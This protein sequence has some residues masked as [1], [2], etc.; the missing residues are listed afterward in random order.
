M[1]R[2][3]FDVIVPLFD[4]SLCLLTLRLF[5]L[6]RFPFLLLLLVRGD[7]DLL[8]YSVSLPVPTPTHAHVKP[9]ITQVYS[10]RQ[11]PPVSNPTLAASSLDQVHSDD[12]L[13]AFCKGMY[14]CTHRISLFVSYNHFVFLLFLYCIHGFYHS[15]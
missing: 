4:D 5:Q 11:N 2:K 7:D 15:S 12:L 9:F 14:Q 13:I 1:F 10:Q 8:V 3:G 6:P